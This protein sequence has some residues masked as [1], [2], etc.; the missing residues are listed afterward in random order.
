MWCFLRSKQKQT[1]SGC[2]GPSVAVN[3]VLCIDVQVFK[4]KEVQGE[5]RVDSRVSVTK[6]RGW[7]FCWRK[8]QSLLFPPGLA[9]LWGWE[10]PLSSS[11]GC[12][13]LVLRS[14][15]P[16]LRILPCSPR[17]GSG[18]FPGDR[19]GPISVWVGDAGSGVSCFP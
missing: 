5:G 1:V 12:L 15:A 10:E 3:Q 8:R 16:E 9:F 7:L 11:T 14:R 19:I 4:K 6:T 13:D 2:H 18:T 17:Y